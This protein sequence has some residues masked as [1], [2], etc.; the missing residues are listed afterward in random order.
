MRTSAGST[1]GVADPVVRSY[2]AVAA[3]WPTVIVMIG[4]VDGVPLMSGLGRI[5][6]TTPAV[7]AFAVT[8]PAAVVRDE[9]DPP[10]VMLSVWLLNT[11][12]MRDASVLVGSALVIGAS[13]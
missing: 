5:L 3:A 2:T 7:V 10:S 6:I 4:S 1:V 13:T 12:S 11:L 8:F 9:V